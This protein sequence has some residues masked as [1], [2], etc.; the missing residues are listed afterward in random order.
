MCIAIGNSATILK[1]SGLSLDDI[2]VKLRQAIHLSI[3]LCFAFPI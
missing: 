2:I 1:N 3:T